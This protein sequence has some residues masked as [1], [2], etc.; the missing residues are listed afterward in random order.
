MTAGKANKGQMV[1]QLWGDLKGAVADISSKFQSSMN[2]TSTTGANQR[3]GSVGATSAMPPGSTAPVM[4]IAASTATTQA[5]STA[6]YP[7][8][9]LPTGTFPT[10]VPTGQ[11]SQVVMASQP[12]Q[13]FGTIG[14]QPQI[15]GSNIAGA[16][17]GSNVPVFDAK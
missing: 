4:P 16:G 14:Q 9:T 7:A 15:S 1:K 2:K 11:P 10:A 6:T 12:Q 3:T 5:T 8:G 13:A 17:S